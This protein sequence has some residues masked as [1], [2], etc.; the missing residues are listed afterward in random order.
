M[1]QNGQT[2]FKNQVINAED[3]VYLVILAPYA[4]K[5]VNKT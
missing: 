5:R 4:L 1:F 2:Y 3:F